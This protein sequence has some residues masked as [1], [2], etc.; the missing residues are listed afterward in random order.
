MIP[1]YKPELINICPSS[2]DD[3][4]ASKTC[5]LD[6]GSNSQFHWDILCCI[7][8]KW[9][10]SLAEAVLVFYLSLLL[11]P[12]SLHP[13]PSECPVWPSGARLSAQLSQI[14]VLMLV[15]VI[16]LADIFKD[17]EQLLNSLRAF[18]WLHIQE[19][20]HPFIWRGPVIVGAFLS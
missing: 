5:T 3:G 1:V 18:G 19:I 10:V 14:L 9:M 20:I 8:C 7:R 6:C 16:S 15:S 12:R 2:G 13:L 17:Q 11:A 4:V